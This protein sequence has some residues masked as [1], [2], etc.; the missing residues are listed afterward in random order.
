V[1]VCEVN[2]MHRDIA[3]PVCEHQT[4]SVIDQSQ[5]SQ[6]PLDTT[7]PVKTELLPAP[8]ILNSSSGP[9]LI[10]LSMPAAVRPCDIDSTARLFFYPGKVRARRCAILRMQSGGHNQVYITASFDKSECLDNLCV[11]FN[12]VEIAGRFTSGRYFYAMSRLYV[13]GQPRLRPIAARAAR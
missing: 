2:G 12:D 10:T 4:E 5:V 1:N 7:E 11:G 3:L 6:Y 8:T 9:I 13:A